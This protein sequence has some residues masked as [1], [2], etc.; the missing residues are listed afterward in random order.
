MSLALGQ[1]E[2]AQKSLEFGAFAHGGRFFLVG[3]GNCVRARAAP[4]LVFA[5]PSVDEL[6]E[7]ACPAVRGLVLM[8]EGQFFLVELAKEFIPRDAL[9]AFVLGS[10][11]S[12]NMPAWLSADVTFTVAGCPPRFS[13]QRRISP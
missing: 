6:M 1:P 8:Q 4:Y 10:K 13:A 3:R 2:F 11:S 12:R 5:A 9:E 7:A